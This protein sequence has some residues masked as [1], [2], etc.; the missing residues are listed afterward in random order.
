MTIVSY[1]Y[2]TTSTD[3]RTYSAADFA[4]A[5]GIILSDGIIADYNTGVL[6]MSASGTNFTT[7][8]TGKA[9]VQGHF[10]EITASETLTVPTGSYSGMI[11]LRVDTATTRK[12]TVAVRTDQN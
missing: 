7:I 2:D 5:F 3:P 10:V 6:G 8:N 9:V 12:A 1:F 4:K 11:V